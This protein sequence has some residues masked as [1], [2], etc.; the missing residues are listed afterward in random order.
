MI[1]NSTVDCVISLKFGTE[2]DHATS[3]VLQMFKVSTFFELKKYTVRGKN[4]Q[5]AF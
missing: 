1:N 2:F 4:V 5:F 3:D